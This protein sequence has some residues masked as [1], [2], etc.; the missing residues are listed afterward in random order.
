MLQPH[1]KFVLR[2]IVCRSN[3]LRHQR[4]VAYVVHGQVHTYVRMRECV[5]FMLCFTCHN[6]QS[7][8]GMYVRIMRESKSA[9]I[10]F[11]CCLAWPVL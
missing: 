1:G 7:P 5:L 6:I 10:N 11:L 4:N 8:T 2:S 9:N 3:R